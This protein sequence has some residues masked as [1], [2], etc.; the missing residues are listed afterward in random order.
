MDLSL[1]HLQIKEL[2]EYEA[3]VKE[4]EEERE[5]YR[6]SLE[7]ELKKCKSD[8]AD[9]ISS[10]NSALVDLMSKYRVALMSKK[11]NE[12][13]RMRYVETLPS[14]LYSYILVLYSDNVFA[15][16][17]HFAIGA[18]FGKLFLRKVS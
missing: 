8:S 3:K 2:K 9:I 18:G 7:Q 16:S 17:A 5:N 11:E 14:F 10:F 13:Q 15:V 12:V 1:H 6:R 4:L